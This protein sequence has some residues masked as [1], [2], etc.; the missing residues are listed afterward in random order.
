MSFLHTKDEPITPPPPST[1]QVLYN[2]K[3]VKW[4][5]IY[6]IIGVHRLIPPVFII[7]MISNNYVYFGLAFI[8]Y[9]FQMAPAPVIYVNPM[10]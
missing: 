1:K 4:I 5:L 9:F 2:F 7:V 3:K 8:T 6:L 10:M